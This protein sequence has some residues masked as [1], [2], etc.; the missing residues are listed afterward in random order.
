MLT[1]SWR[2]SHSR[3]AV[4]VF[5]RT[6]IRVKSCA[7]AGYGLVVGRKQI[8]LLWIKDAGPLESIIILLMSMNLVA[9]GCLCF[10]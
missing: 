4:D 9:A 5:Q 2:Q 7:F 10:K 3:R 6:Y 8:A 1:K